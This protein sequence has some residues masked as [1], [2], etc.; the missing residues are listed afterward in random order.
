MPAR[1]DAQPADV[2]PLAL[3]GRAGEQALETTVDRRRRSSASSYAGSLARRAVYRSA[4][5]ISFGV[6]T[7][8]VTR[9]SR[10]DNANVM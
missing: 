9:L 1:S 6:A 5:I 4:M 8:S 2:T 10:S 3:P 7:I